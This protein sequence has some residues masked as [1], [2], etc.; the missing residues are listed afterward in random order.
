M[1]HDTGTIYYITHET[2]IM[3]YTAV[4]FLGNVSGSYCC[5]HTESGV[6]CIHAYRY[7][8]LYTRYFQHAH[9]IPIVGV[10]KRGEY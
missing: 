6:L 7:I 1:M 4:R 10:G 8:L 9:S 5:M 3:H 2:L